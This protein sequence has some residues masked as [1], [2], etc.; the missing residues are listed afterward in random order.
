MLYITGLHALNIPCSLDTCG[1][2]HSCAIKWDTPDIANS[3]DNI[4]GDYGI[5]KNITVDFLDKSKKYNVANHIRAILDL[6]I[7]NNLSIVQGMKNDF[8]CNDNYT[9]EIFRK[10]S[11]LKSYNNWSDIDRLMSKEYMM[12]WIQFKKKNN[13]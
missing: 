8:I 13:L 2:W 4:F 7:E 12:K 10:V 1:D 6:M 3:D 5:E 9:E 11:E